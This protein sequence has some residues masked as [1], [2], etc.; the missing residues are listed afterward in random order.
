MK[1]WHL[2]GDVGGTNMR[3][4][5]LDSEGGLSG[6]VTYPSG[7]ELAVAQ[8]C[9]EFIAGQG[10]QPASIV[11][12]AAGP[13][14]AGMVQFTNVTQS[15]SETELEGLSPGARVRILNDF[16]AAAWSLATAGEGDV[17]LLQG[18]LDD[19]EAPRL[20]VGPGT[21]LGV[22]AL[23]WAQ[24]QPQIVAGE[25]G[26]VRLAPQSREECGIFEA[27]IEEQP[28]FRMGDGL[29]VEAEAI[30]SG[31]GMPAFYRAVAQAGGHPAPLDRTA[32]IFAAAR[33]GDDP[34][35]VQ[36]VSLFRDY[37]GGLIGDLGLAFGAFGG[38][39]VTGGVAQANRWIFDETFM[40]AV[41][42]G[43]R[44]SG[45]RR[46]LP[47]CLYQEPNF[48]LLGARNYIE[49]RFR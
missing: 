49:Y 31:L 40:Q 47:V 34:A 1:I 46:T 26:H 24:G 37:L 28:S 2:V 38:V 33:T 4:A 29:A 5:A 48:G 43:G 22:G 30:L 32:E 19:L 13:V 3:L 20:I 15:L 7:G 8:A 45:L 18:R 39:F 16:E 42:Q 21:G 9:A 11:I 44:Y 36:A 25:G 27:L 41:Q 35:A 12:A 10:G 23:V 17:D 6:H 14:K